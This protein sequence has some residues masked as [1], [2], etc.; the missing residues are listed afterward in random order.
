[1]HQF[2]FSLFFKTSSLA[3]KRE[4]RERKTEKEGS[5]TIHCEEGEE[6]SLDCGRQLLLQQELDMAELVAEAFLS[7]AFE[8]LFELLASP[9]FRS[10]FREKKSIDDQLKLL[11]EK[12]KNASLLLNDAEERQIT[13]EKVKEW[14]DDLKDV[15]FRADDLVEEIKAEARSEQERESGSTMS[16]L[17]KKIVALVTPFTEFD[18][19]VQGETGNILKDLG[20][21]LERASRLRLKHIDGAPKTR[22]FRSIP[23]PL[24]DERYV[25]GRDAD[26]EEILRLLLS[27]EVWGKKLGVIPIVGMGG[28]GKTTLAQL[29]Y[30]HDRVKDHEFQLKAWVTVS[31]EFDICKIAKTIMEQISP[32]T[33]GIEEPAELQQRL[34]EALR[35]KKFLLVLDDVWDESYDNWDLLRCTFPSEES[36][37]RI[38]VTT[39]SKKVAAN[40]KTGELI[41]ELSQ[42]SEL[43]CWNIFVDHALNGDADADPRLQDIGKK[44]VEKCKGVPLAVKSIGGLLRSEKSP[45]KWESILRSHVWESRSNELILPSLWLSYCYLP[46]RLKQ[47]FAYCSIFP[48]D[49]PIKKEKIIL[50]WMGEGLLQFDKK[51]ERLEEV[52]QE[53]LDNLI[54][55]S[56][57]QCSSHDESVFVMHDLVHDLAMFVSREFCFRFDH[58]TD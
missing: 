15:I 30:N 33:P 5:A 17:K 24:R 22:S 9:E 6:N 2:E 48:K 20:F 3:T 19:F 12:L 31:T 53:Y 51:E 21:L 45:E 28:L 43:D 56:L 32:G 55:R 7:A 8:K 1:M 27:G 44:I 25:H 40:V 13:D 37:S 52:G 54:S 36:G 29:V 18:K 57:F 4:S 47:C 38:I 10:F 46:S 26:K 35:G 23:A 41:Y 58:D 14:L 39:R 16:M 11:N 49:Y 34:K 42:V 50:F